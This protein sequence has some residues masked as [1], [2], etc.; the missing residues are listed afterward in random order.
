MRSFFLSVVVL[1]SVLVLSAC[2][3]TTKNA[4]VRS[5]PLDTCVVMGSR[6]G[7]MGDPI[8]KVYD[9]QEVKFCCAPCIEEFEADPEHYLALIREEATP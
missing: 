9:G 7:S 3:V 4:G 5:Y 6:L 8:V 1:S 2:S